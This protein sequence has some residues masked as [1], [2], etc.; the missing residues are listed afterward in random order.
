MIYFVVVTLSTA[1]YGDIIVRSSLAKLCVIIL[2]FLALVLI[3]NQ[4]SE[5]IRLM[6]LQSTYARDSFVSTNDSTHVIICGNLSGSSISNFSKELFHP[7]HDIRNL[8]AV[9]LKKQYPSPEMVEI[10]QSPNYDVLLRYLQGDPLEE[11]SLK[12]ADASKASACIVLTD[13]YIEDPVAQDHKNILLGI[14]VK[15]YVANNNNNKHI[16]ICMQLIKPES[17][18]HFQRFASRFRVTRTRRPDSSGRRVQDEPSSQ[19]LLLSRNNRSPR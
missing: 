18:S 7:D 4:T 12:R 16:R 15:N 11:K 2:I 8:I 6:G 14:A 1:G 13:K 5:L 10:L 17:K 3:P 19:E 9:I